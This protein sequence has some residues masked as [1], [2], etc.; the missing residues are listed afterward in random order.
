[1]PPCEIILEHADET[2]LRVFAQ[3]GATDKPHISNLSKR[4]E[5]EMK[6]SMV[7]KPVP[8]SG[9]GDTIYGPGERAHAGVARCGTTRRRG[10]H[11]NMRS[12]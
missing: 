11:P 12:G 2:V 9:A 10:T 6:H 3:V 7:Q 8:R 1:M 5:R 4:A